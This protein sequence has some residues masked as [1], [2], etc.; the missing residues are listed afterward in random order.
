M[1]TREQYLNAL[2]LIDQYHHQLNLSNVRHNPLS[3]KTEIGSWFAGLSKK[4]SGRLCKLLLNYR[5]VKDGKPFKYVEDVN[6]FEFMR[7]R[8]AGELTWSEFAELRGLDKDYA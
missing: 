8:N 6:K 1:I 4:P 7:L 5:W 3:D 2:E